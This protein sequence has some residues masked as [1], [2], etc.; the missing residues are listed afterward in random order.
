ML[1][2][3]YSQS[4]I[5][6][7]LINGLNGLPFCACILDLANSERCFRGGKSRS[8]QNSTSPTTNLPYCNLTQATQDRNV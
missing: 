2:R 3:T 7:R 6:Y 5:T 1:A 8:L 4:V